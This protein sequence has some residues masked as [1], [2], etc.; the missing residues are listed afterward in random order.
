MI[1]EDIFFTNEFTVVAKLEESNTSATGLVSKIHLSRCLYLGCWLTCCFQ[2]CIPLVDQQLL[3]TCC[4]FLGECKYIIFVI[5]SVITSRIVNVCTFASV[6]FHWCLLAFIGPG[7]F[8]KLLAAFVSGSTAKS[9]GIIR[10]IT[11]TSAELRDA[12]TANRSQHK[13]QVSKQERL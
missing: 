9:G 7:E 11:P 12:P 10:K 8:R 2:D 6:F 4:P 3:Y 1:P 13:L 5:A